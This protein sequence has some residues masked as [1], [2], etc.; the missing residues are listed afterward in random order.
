MFGV[1]R[2][3]KDIELAAVEDGDSAFGKYRLV[4]KIADGG[5]AT[6]YLAT[7]VGPGG[8]EKPCA[9]KRIRSEYSATPSFRDMLVREAKVAALLNHPN[10]VQVFDFGQVEDEYYLT[11]E[12]VE[13]AALSQILK[14][15]A[16]KR[17]PIGLGPVLQVTS[18]LAR[19]VEY[20]A[21]GLT[22]DGV[23][24]QLVHRDISPS[25]VL[26]SNTGVIKLTDFGIVKVLDAP[27]GTAAGVIKGKYAYMSPEQLR[28]EPL[29]SR[30]DVFSLGVVMYEALTKKRLFRRDDVA[31][32]IAAVL[33]GSVP[34]PSTIAGDIPA[35]VDELVLAM[36]SKRAA[37]RPSASEVRARVDALASE[38]GAR[39]TDR[40]ATLARGDNEADNDDPSFAQASTALLGDVPLI[41]TASDAPAVM[42]DLA[43]A[44]PSQ[45]S[46]HMHGAPASPNTAAWWALAIVLLA[47]TSTLA[48]WAFVLS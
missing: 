46:I 15:A 41:P 40:L 1:A 37:E 34:R 45:T 21:S 26:V 35:E 36:L 4:R 7:S 32:T 11:M 33:G 24:T 20:L 31:S 19:A 10:I 25:N 17:I 14:R 16:R 3:G 44:Y 2:P 47:I 12:W 9:V 8:F 23:R 30:S 42:P 13:G 48:F 39:G 5:M 18:A 38:H 28:G 6:I 43:S 29:D 27:Q 22:V